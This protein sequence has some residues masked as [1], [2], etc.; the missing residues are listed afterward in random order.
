MQWISFF[1]IDEEE[2]RG[3]MLKQTEEASLQPFDAWPTI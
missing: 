3:Q 1:L 2:V